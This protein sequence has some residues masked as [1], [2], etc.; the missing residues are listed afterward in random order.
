MLK[1]DIYPLTSD[2]EDNIVRN[3]ISKCKTGAIRNKV[4]LFRWFN[5]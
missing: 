3:D 1:C 4:S 5:I 2:D